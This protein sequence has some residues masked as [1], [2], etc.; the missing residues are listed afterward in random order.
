M[1]WIYIPGAIFL[2]PVDGIEYFRVL[3]ILRDRLNE[4]IVD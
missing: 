2:E 4:K 1:H 3:E